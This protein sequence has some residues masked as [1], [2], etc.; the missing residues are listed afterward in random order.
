MSRQAI[1]HVVPVYETQITGIAACEVSVSWIKLLDAFGKVIMECK[2]KQ[3]DQVHVPVQDL[4]AL[5][6][7]RQGD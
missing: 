5:V 4:I 1:L 7:S 3:A 2:R 6:K